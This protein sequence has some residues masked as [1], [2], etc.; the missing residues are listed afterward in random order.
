MAKADSP[1]QAKNRDSNPLIFD[2]EDMDPDIPQ[3]SVMS[4][5]PQKSPSRKRR[6]GS[7]R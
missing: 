3:T 2:V 7:R 6:T 5:D 4:L 1:P